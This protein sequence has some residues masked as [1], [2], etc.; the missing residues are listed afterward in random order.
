MELFPFHDTVSQ[1]TQ[2]AEKRYA[3]SFLSDQTYNLCQAGDKMDQ[4][5]QWIYSILKEGAKSNLETGISQRLE[6]G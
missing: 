4:N 6:G 1:I 2:P 3:N 5:D